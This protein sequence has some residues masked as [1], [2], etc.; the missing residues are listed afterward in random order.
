MEDEGLSETVVVVIV[1]KLCLSLCNPRTE[2]PPGSSVQEYWSGLPVPFTGD[3]PNPGIKPMSPALASGLFTTAP[4][5]KSSEMEMTLNSSPSNPFLYR[6][7]HRGPERAGDLTK[8]DI[9]PA[10]TGKISARFKGKTTA[11]TVLREEP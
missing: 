5:G 1:P 3:L 8:A 4:P 9:L 2:S 11:F 10:N 6:Q 7:E